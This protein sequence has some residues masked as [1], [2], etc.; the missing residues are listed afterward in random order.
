MGYSRVIRRRIRQRKGGVDVA[1]DLNL[2]VAI[3]QDSQG[4]QT[5]THSETHSQA[6]A[7]DADR[8]DQQATRKDDDEPD[9]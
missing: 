6:V 9:A 2:A 4:E 5:V 8:T 3:N 1:A 7:D